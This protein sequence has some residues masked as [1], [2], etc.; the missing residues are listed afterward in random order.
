M[1]LRVIRDA[2]IMLFHVGG[3]GRGIEEHSLLVASW[4][5]AHITENGPSSPPPCLW[6]GP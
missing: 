2:D 1:T 4:N 5:V 3:G 6:S